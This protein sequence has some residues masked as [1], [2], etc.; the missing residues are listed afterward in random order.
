MTLFWAGFFGFGAG[1][2]G[3]RFMHKGEGF[4]LMVLTV[5]LGNLLALLMIEGWR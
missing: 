5:M 4:D 2:S 3:S 1:F